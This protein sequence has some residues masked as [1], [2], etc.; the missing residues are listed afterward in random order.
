M[1]RLENLTRTFAN[2]ILLDRISLHLEAG[3]VAVIRGP[4][5]CG[6]TTLLR[7]IA[8]L[9]R[10]N[11]GRI[12]I[13]GER[14]TDGAWL[15]PPWERG[16]ALAFQDDGLWPHLTIRQH[17]DVLAAAAGRTTGSSAPAAVSPADT[18]P[19]G[20][21]GQIPDA[22]R[23]GRSPA[24]PPTSASLS[25]PDSRPS[26]AFRPSPDAGS[27]LA[28][29]GLTALA[30]RYPATLSGGEARRVSVARALVAAPRVLLLDEPLAHLDAASRTL[31]EQALLRHGRH[32]GRATLIVSHESGLETL[33]GARLLEFV[34]GRLDEPGSP[35]PGPA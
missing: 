28:D 15:L 33:L 31:V 24:S 16:V 11:D 35:G 7:L 30:D 25:F 22:G 1:L 4:S 14:V 10:P 20:P 17:L 23:A 12:L 3:G 29:L 21:T 18:G 13:G 19:G 27:L 34:A 5:G 2:R 6:K 26:P 8:G 9:D 32:P